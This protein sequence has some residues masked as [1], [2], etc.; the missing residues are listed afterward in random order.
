VG[1]EITLRVDRKD[2]GRGA[3]AAATSNLRVRNA[4]GRDVVDGIDLHVRAGE[5]VG[6]VG[7]EGNGQSEVL[8][9]ISG[10]QRVSGGSVSLNGEPVD[11]LSVLERRQRGLGSIPEDR[12]A[13]GLATGASVGENL[14]ATRLGDRR[15]NRRGLL[16]LRA[17]R[18]QA[19]ALIQRFSIRVPGPNAAVATLSGGNMQKVVVARELAEQPRVLLVSQPTRGVDLSA[20]QFIWRT[21]T[22]ARDNGTAVLL[23]SAD[24]SELL[25]LSD[26]LV[27]LYRGRIVAAFLNREGLTPETLG[28]Y[29]LGLQTQTADEMQAGLA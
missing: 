12:I 15:Y 17:I 19:E 24:L 3:V 25:A 21:I 16:D 27:V 13:Q 8:E 29:M 4:R 11:G 26:R 20:T 23:S 28:T 10:L 9:A 2:T 5:I 6:L 18:S 14:V 7:V 22:E 1:R